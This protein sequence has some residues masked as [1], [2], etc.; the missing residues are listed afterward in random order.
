V[1]PLPR[2]EHRTCTQVDLWVQIHPHLDRYVPLV[3][4]PYFLRPAE[5]LGPLFFKMF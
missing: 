1:S 4:N 3:T 5:Y 2:S